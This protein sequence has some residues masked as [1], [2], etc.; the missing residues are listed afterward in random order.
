M[1]R[2][3]SEAPR[4]LHVFAISARP[5]T[6]QCTCRL[7]YAASL[8]YTFV[9]W[10]CCW[11][12]GMMACLNICTPAAKG[13]AVRSETTQVRD[14]VGGTDFPCGTA[15]PI[16]SAFRLAGIVHSFDAGTQIYGQD[17]A[18]WYFYVVLAGCVRTVRH[19]ADGRRHVGG[20]YIAGDIFGVEASNEH[21]FDAEAITQSQI[22]M[23]PRRRI[24]EL[25]RQDAYLSTDLWSLT[26]AALS[27]ARRLNFLLARNTAE[28]KLVGFLG[29][30]AARRG[31]GFNVDLPMTRR[32]IGDYLGLAIETVSRTFGELERKGELEVLSSR[33][34]RL[35]KRFFSTRR[36]SD[37]SVASPSPGI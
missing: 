16:G 26:V 11:C 6:K 30:M 4:H 3:R 14:V 33:H 5:E 29:D 9:H 12:D 32:D 34:I 10:R 7:V 22:M 8:F 18:A 35:T 15:G 27:E 24:I 36:G 21:Y 31:D 1:L 2:N 13:C 19:M 25:A 20:F 28:E 17:E 23:A 37:P